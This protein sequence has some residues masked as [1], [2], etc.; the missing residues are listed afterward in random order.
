MPFKTFVAGEILTASDVNTQ[1]MN[2]AIAVFADASARDTAI[3]SPVEGQFVFRTDD[4]VLEYWDGSAWEEYIS[5]IEVEYLV[6]G[7]G[8][9][10]NTG[11]DQNVNA[12]GGGGAGGY[13]CSVAGESSG[14]SSSPRANATFEPKRSY[15]ITIGAGGVRTG[16]RT[17]TSTPGSPTTLGSIYVVGGGAGG[18]ND[19]NNIPES[20]ASGAGAELGYLVAGRGIDGLGFAGGITAT[21]ATGGGGGG[22][23]QAGAAGG[24][25]GNGGDGISSSITGTATFRGGG[26]GGGKRNTDDSAPGGNG[27][28]G[29]GSTLAAK[30]GVANTGGGGA[31]GRSSGADTGNSPGGNGGSGV[32]IFRVDTGTSV[33]F[34]GGV[35]HTTTTVGA[36]TA[37]IVTAAG[38]TDTVTIG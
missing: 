29:G 11:S 10:G 2:Q 1:L 9:A 31:G 33:S 17:G 27:G 15:P 26:G 19:T 12:R 24:S 25:G 20:G 32:V 30:S 36:K 23:G 14:G 3:T 22:A 4:D 37:Y 35:T 16:Y 28:G 6:I 7:G 21:N 5:A 34:S 18:N 8:G 38:P 13:F